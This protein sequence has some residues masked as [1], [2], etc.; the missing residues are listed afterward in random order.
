M[1][2]S[3]IR[4]GVGHADQPSDVALA[5]L[6]HIL[7]AESGIYTSMG[8]QEGSGTR[9]MTL[10]SDIRRYRGVQDRKSVVEGKSGDLGGRRIIKKKIK[11]Q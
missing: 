2:S 3:D 10:S 6:R 1:S 8:Y 5:R 11:K 7:E 4:E 9:E